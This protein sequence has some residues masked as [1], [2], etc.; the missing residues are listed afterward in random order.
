V[1]V[2][3][4]QRQIPCAFCS[5]FCANF[6]VGRSSTDPSLSMRFKFGMLEQT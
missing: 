3:G 2:E 1:E 4:L 6:I 5:Q